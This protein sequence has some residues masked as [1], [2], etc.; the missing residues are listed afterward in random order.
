MYDIITFGSATSDVFLRL[1]E[2]DYQIK[3]SPRGIAKESLCLP[4]GAKL[5]LTQ[6]QTASGGGGT[7]AA[8]TFSRQGFKVAYCGKIGNDKPGLMVLDDLMKSKVSTALCLRDPVQP[9][10]FSAVLSVQQEERTVLIYHGACHLMMPEEVPW[11]NIKKAKWFYLAPLSNK[12][13]GLFAPLVHFAQDNKIKVAANLGHTQI[14]LRKETLKPI[15]AGIDL[16]ILNNEEALSL[17]GFDAER[18]EAIIEEL[19]LLCPKAIILITKGKEGAFVYFQ[20]MFYESGIINVPVV[21]KTG[22]GDAYASGFLAGFLQSNQIEHAMQLATANA[23]GCIQEVGAKN[24][25]LKKNDFGPWPKIVVKS[26][27]LLLKTQL[28]KL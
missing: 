19:L 8:C 15:L 4:L 12:S 11:E 2:N 7:N 1:D 28:V 13:A 17:T 22:A 16:L 23:T 14:N 20:G 25:I 27:K 9:T 6:M 10:A 5:F 18:E 3:P 24:G 21:E 26:R